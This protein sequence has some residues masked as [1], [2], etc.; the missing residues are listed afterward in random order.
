MAIQGYNN[1]SVGAGKNTYQS[2]AQPKTYKGFSTINPLA[3]NGAL[4]DLELI[5]QDLINH[6]HIKKGEK[7]ENPTF[8]T[9]IWDMLYEPLT[10][11]LK[12][13]ITNDVTGII[14]SDPRVKVISSIITQIDKGLQLE[15]TLVYLPYNIQ[16][17]MQFTFDRNNGLI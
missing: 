10:D 12:Q 17:S 1:I 11:Q 5:K 8:G 6:F 3:K 15:F 16:Q 4:Y 14:N 7:L 13:L 9:I 2:T